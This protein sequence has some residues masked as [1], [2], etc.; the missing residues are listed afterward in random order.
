[1]VALARGIEDPEAPAGLARKQPHKKGPE[2]QEALRGLVGPHQRLLLQ[3]QL[4]HLDFLSQE[5]G[6]LRQEVEQRMGSFDEAFQKLDQIPGIGRRIAE[7][8]LAEIRVDMGRFPTAAHL[9]SWAKVCP[10]NHESA[11]KRAALAVAHTIL[12]TIHHLLSRGTG[13]QELGA[14]TLMNETDNKPCWER[15]AALSS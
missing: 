6:R 1:M 14:N 13:Y 5:I 3:S 7:D 10:G 11:G 12:A 15:F 9:A 8:V 2:L 4:R